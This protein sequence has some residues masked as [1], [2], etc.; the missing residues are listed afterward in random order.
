VHGAGGLCLASAEAV[1]TITNSTFS[2]NSSQRGGGAI[3]AANGATVVLVASTLYDNSAGRGGG[4]VWTDGTLI[5]QQSIV[6]GNH[7]AGGNEIMIE[8]TG[9]ASFESLGYNLV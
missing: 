6:A 9:A 4:G 1:A 5:L 7:A 8:R 3:G 2:R